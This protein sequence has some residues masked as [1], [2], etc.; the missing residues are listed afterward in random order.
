ML[1]AV[2]C[3]DGN[4]LFPEELRLDGRVRFTSIQLRRRLLQR[5]WRLGKLVVRSVRRRLVLHGRGVVVHGVS[6]R[7]DGARGLDLLRG[8]RL[9]FVLCGQ[10]S[11]LGCMPHVRRKHVLCGRCRN[12]VH[13]VPERR[14]G[15]GR[16]DLR[17]GVLVLRGQFP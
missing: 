17:H 16:L 14:N 12:V 3:S 10:L 11:E 13:G 8:V 6:R 4:V 5:Q 1:D 2:L 15:A 7:Q 9:L